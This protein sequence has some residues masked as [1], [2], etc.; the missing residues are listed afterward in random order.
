LRERADPTTLRAMKSRIVRIAVLSL[1]LAGC[2]KKEET[3]P[4]PTPDPAAAPA[5]TAAPTPAPGAGGEPI[6]VTGF[7]TPESVLYDAA[8]DRYLVSNINGAPPDGKDDNGFISIVKPDGT[9]ETLKWIDG[10]AA[11]IDLS[12]PK[13]MA[14]V[15]D[16]LFVADVTAVRKFDVNTGK[17]LAS[18]Q[19]MNTKF[20]NDV[21]PAPENGVYVTDTGVNPDFSPGGTDAV[22]LIKADNT[23]EKVFGDA[24][25][26]G[27][28]GIVADGDDGVLVNTFGSGELYRLNKEGKHMVI[29]APKGQLDGL[30]VLPDNNIAFSSWEAKTVFKGPRTGP[31]TEWVKDV[32]SPA[33][34][35]IDTKR[36]RLI[37]PLFMKNE[38]LIH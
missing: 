4:A 8:R 27:P 17:Q 1:A 30:A 33:D 2:K 29:K 10:T 25:L 7:S 18:I 16:A 9:V 12:A 28:N 13:G 38:V 20:L 5:P 36:N 11:D 32:E 31:F 21:A 23:V 22:Y 3:P 19:I 15:G 34:F 24:S 26:G 37:I 6:R 35:A 14:L